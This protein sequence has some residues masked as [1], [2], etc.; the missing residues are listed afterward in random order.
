MEKHGND[1]TTNVNNI[2]S[3]D[4]RDVAG[5]LCGW[6]TDLFQG[7]SGLQSPVKEEANPRRGR[8]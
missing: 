8:A 5:L 7:S 4:S 6:P 3:D 1:D 2:E